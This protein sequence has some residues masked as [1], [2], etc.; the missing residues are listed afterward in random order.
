M[1]DTTDPAVPIIRVR[2]LRRDFKV[3]ARGRGR[4]VLRAVNDASFDVMPGETLGVVGE[5]GSG[6]STIGR[7][8]VGLLPASGGEIELFGETIT[9]PLGKR[10]L[11]R[12][13]HR[14]QFVF[15]DPHAAMNP[16]MRISD[17]IAE[18]IDIQGGW[19]RKARADRVSE[20]LDLV[21]LSAQFADRFPHEFSGGQ[22]QR[23]VIARALA[24]DPDFIVCDEAVAALDVSMQ[25]QVINL[26]MDLQDRLGLSYLFIAHDLAVVRAVS[27]RIAV[28]YAGEIVELSGKSAL[29]ED[30]RHPYTQALLAAIPRPE[31]GVRKPPIRG[32]VPSMLNRPAGCALC[33]RCPSA[34]D[35]C[36]TEAPALR[37]VA[38]GHSVACHLYDGA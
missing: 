34:F 18:P 19:S 31:V 7:M 10:A 14:L 26:L 38:P 22:R 20:L 24:L 4:G 33:P 2:N 11:A 21:G 27:T 5:S 13:R 3:G 25:A 28:L 15:Q 6:K 30:P 36:K 8:L 32:E 12:V 17:I 16:R 35:R 1:K 23:I 29:Y 9:G 37:E